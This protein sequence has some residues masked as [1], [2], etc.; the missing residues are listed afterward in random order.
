MAQRRYRGPLLMPAVSSS[1]RQLGASGQQRK[2]MSSST[3]PA[4]SESAYGCRWSRLRRRWDLRTAL[5]GADHQ[6]P[7]RVVPRR[8]PW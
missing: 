7:L 3:S 5:C 2:S 1:D 4:P 8:T 6:D